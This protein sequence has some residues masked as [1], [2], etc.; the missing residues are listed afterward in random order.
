MATR[1]LHGVNTFMFEFHISR[2]ARDLY[3]VK[4]VLF[5]FN[6]N[7]VFAS[8]AASRALAH[9]MNRMRGAELDP[10]RQVNPGALFA[11]GL[12]DEAAHATLAYYRETVAPD[13]MED[14]LV[15]FG[16]QVGVAELDRLLLAFVDRFPGTAVYNGEQSPAEFLEGSTEGISHRAVVFE[17]LLLLWLAN[18]NKAFTPFKELFDDA[19]LKQTTIY[20]EVTER[21]PAY[22]ATQPPLG[23]EGDDLFSLLLSIFDEAGGGTLS[24]QLTRLRGRWGFAVA[25]LLRRALLAGDVLK[26]EEVALWLQYNP[27]TAETIARRSRSNDFGKGVAEVPSF[28]TSPAEYEAFSPDQDWM[29]RTVLIAKSTYVWLHQLSRT[30]GRE[31]TRLD[32]IPDEEL[33]ILAR[34]G[35]NALWLIGV[36][37]RS[38]AS[39]TIK[40][41]CG[42]A[43]AVASA[44]SLY[45]YS[46]AQN[47]GG[48]AA[49][50]NLRDRAARFGLRLASDMVPNHMGI[51]ST[52]VLEHPEWFLS[53]PDSPYPAYSF[54]G[55]DLSGDERVEIKIDDH[56]YQQTDA[57]VVFR[58]RD[59]WTGNTEYIYHGNDGTSF[60]WN[61]TAQLN[62]RSAAVREQVMQTILH[63]ARLFPIIRF[64]A[65]MTLAKIHIQRLWFPTPG[66]GGS[67]PS[68]AEHAMTTEEFDAALPNEFWREVVDRVAVEVP[69]TLLLAEAFWL[70]E[71]YF[72]RTLGMHRVYN[73][74]FMVMLRDEDNAKYREVLKKT[75]EFDPGIMKRYVNFMS[76][77]DERT[78]IDQFGSGDKYFGVATM[79]ATLPGLPMFGHG[80]VEGFTE[81]YGMEYYRPRYEESADQG[82]V[83]RHQ[84]EIAPLLHQR[85]LFAESEHFLLYDFWKDTGSVDENVFAYSNR[86][87]GQRAL[88]LYNNTFG[89]TRGTIHRSAA[90]MDKGAGMLKQQ[91]LA[92]ALALPDDPARIFA[93]REN[94]S[95]L[96]YLRRTGEIAREGISFSL[97]AYQYAALVAW[98]ELQVDAEHGWDKLCDVLG[99]R[100][101]DDLEGALISLELATLHD[102]LRHA[103]A[104]A[105]VRKLAAL[106][107]DLEAPRSPKS[108]TKNGTPKLLPENDIV[109]QFVRLAVTFAEEARAAYSLRVKP[110]PVE[111][112]S[113]PETNREAAPLA[114]S[115]EE[116]VPGSSVAMAEEQS[117]RARLETRARERLMALLTLPALES[118]FEEVWPVPARTVLP[119]RSPVLN[120]G[121]VWAP[122]LAWLLISIAAESLDVAD[123]ATPA[124]AIFDQ[125]RLRHVLAEVFAAVHFRGDDRGEG[126]GEDPWRAAAA[127]RQGGLAK[128]PRPTSPRAGHTQPGFAPQVWEQGDVRWLTQVH[129]ADGVTYFNKE[130]FEELLWWQALAELVTHAA[131]PD[132]ALGPLEF[133]LRESTAAAAAAGYRLTVGVEEVPAQ[134]SDEPSSSTAAEELPERAQAEPESASSPGDRPAYVIVEDSPV[135]EV[136]S[137]KGAELTEPGDMRSAAVTNKARAVTNEAVVVTSKAM[138]EVPEPA[139]EPEP[140]PAPETNRTKG[141]PR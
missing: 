109:Q 138:A 68:R 72:V 37:E 19:P 21:L 8:P 31:I 103:L 102:A 25:E 29:P 49:Y 83:D 91:S 35:M 38:R 139:E 86:S 32:Q 97:R 36:W 113:L 1:H 92:E 4:E 22:F 89:E 120:A 40:R 74:A 110:S 47:L 28:S 6:G 61:D 57:A 62:Y 46:I 63:V 133:R 114:R 79:M 129:D 121:A 16:E 80:Q 78:A 122:A 56:Y 10:A 5:S 45:D 15:W 33:E 140:V 132:K 124:L 137:A 75:L 14:A 50:R 81:K 48:E 58:R 126:R 7:A 23:P 41:L 94:A 106:A 55:P 3:Q 42:N 98:R 52:W 2:E 66:S 18:A 70:M 27:P 24:E 69:G 84:R 59:T 128:G 44:Y 17:E 93:Y 118:Q 76:N 65:A 77:P 96:T 51:D 60:P 64:D 119:S 11:M 101:V 13:V 100:P 88:I 134:R 108:P 104:P 117:E 130:G 99:G 54:E 12:I 39:Q 115:A 107:E 82:L 123:P 26:E 135:S 43:E 9:R 136:P 95:G 141:V 71:G 73:S 111:A 105:V 127:G 112:A 34:R 131:E 30:Y 67:I 116:F 125:F 20:D 85:T 53:R 90:Y 87:G